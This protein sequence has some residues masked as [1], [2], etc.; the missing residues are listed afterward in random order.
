MS[1]V[2]L[3]AENDTGR[4]TAERFK[5]QRSRSRINIKNFTAGKSMPNMIGRVVRP[6]LVSNVRLRNCPAIIRM[7]GL[8]V[9]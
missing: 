9:R 4:S 7:H 8:S 1:P 3:L 2:I 5:A 6:G